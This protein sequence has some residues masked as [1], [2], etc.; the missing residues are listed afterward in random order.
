M[1][2]KIQNRLEILRGMKIMVPGCEPTSAFT[3]PTLAENRDCK[4]TIVDLADA[5]IAIPEATV[6]SWRNPLT[7]FFVLPDGPPPAV[8]DCNCSRTDWYALLREIGEEVIA[9]EDKCREPFSSSSGQ[10]S[11]AF[12]MRGRNPKGIF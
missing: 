2:F 3:S 1:S 11:D 6:I 9:P 12:P 8:G 4:V 10:I 7:R 5:L